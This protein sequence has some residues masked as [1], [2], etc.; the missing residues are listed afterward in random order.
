[1]DTRVMVTEIAIRAI[2]EIAAGMLSYRIGDNKR[3]LSDDFDDDDLQMGC[4]FLR[5]KLL[6]KEM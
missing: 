2:G 1:M 6:Y 5:V 3:L 4:L